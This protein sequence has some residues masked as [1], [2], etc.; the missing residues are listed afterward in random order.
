M[1]KD[2]IY[3]DTSTTYRTTGPIKIK[4]NI[5]S[6]DDLAEHLPSY[7]ARSNPESKEAK[8]EA[9]W[10]NLFFREDFALLKFKPYANYHIAIRALE[11]YCG[12]LSHDLSF[13]D[14][15]ESTAKD[16]ISCCFLL[17]F[18]YTVSDFGEQGDD[19]KQSYNISF[20]NKLIWP[21]TRW[22]ARY[23][24]HMYK[25]VIQSG[26]QNP[27]DD[28]HRQIYDL[29]NEI[30]YKFPK[31]RAENLFYQVLRIAESTRL[32]DGL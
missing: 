14:D 11:C 30:K 18:I 21:K 22:R 29:L 4:D 7:I 17:K 10:V 15:L 28:L 31:L 25:F 27:K 16:L 12:F 20:E 23:R 2:D 26:A 13:K 6:D 32:D 1:K 9:S 3:E 24:S 19:F 8:R 5:I